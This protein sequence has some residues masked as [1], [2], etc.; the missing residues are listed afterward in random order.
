MR[1]RLPIVA[2]WAAGLAFCLWFWW[3]VISV[4]TSWFCCGV[5]A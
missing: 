2:F 5:F 1:K 3:T 4:I